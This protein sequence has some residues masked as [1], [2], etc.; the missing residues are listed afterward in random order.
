MEMILSS[1]KALVHNKDIQCSDGSLFESIIV[2][3]A[4]VK[5]SDYNPELVCELQTLRPDW[6]LNSSTK[7]AYR[8]SELFLQAK[9]QLSKPS[10][11][12]KDTHENNL[13]RWL[14]SYVTPYSGNYDYDFALALQE[15]APNWFKSDTELEKQQLLKDIAIMDNDQAPS[16]NSESPFEQS[17]A[18]A[19]FKYTN[20]FNWSYDKEFTMKIMKMKPLWFNLDSDQ[21]LQDRLRYMTSN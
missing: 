19:L 8:K 18:F 17:V 11:A 21:K 13:A 4:S 12:A 9:S 3:L 7:K 20:P 5:S 14:R 2:N 1:L 15:V 16:C 6:F 10:L